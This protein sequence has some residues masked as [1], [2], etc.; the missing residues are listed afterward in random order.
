MSADSFQ[1][2]VE[3]AIRK[4]GQLYDLDDFVDCVIKN[5]IAIQMRQV[6]PESVPK[7]LSKAILQTRVSWLT[8]GNKL[9]E[10]RRATILQDS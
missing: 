2:L 9:S 6:I 5:G 1:H 8:E 4:K 10:T 7:R 3:G